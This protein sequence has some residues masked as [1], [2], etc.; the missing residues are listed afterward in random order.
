[1]QKYK[2]PLLRGYDYNTTTQFMNKRQ[3]NDIS[4]GYTLC[5]KITGSYAFKMTDLHGELNI[6]PASH[7]KSYKMIVSSNEVVIRLGRQSDHFY[8]IGNIDT[9]T[10]IT[11]LSSN[12]QHN[13]IDDDNYSINESI[14]YSKIA[15]ENGLHLDHYVK[16]NQ[17]CLIESNDYLSFT[18]KHNDRKNLAVMIN[19][20]ENEH[21]KETYS[22]TCSCHLDYVT[23]EL[24]YNLLENIPYQIVLELTPMMKEMMIK[25][26]SPNF[27]VCDN[28]DSNND[29][30]KYSKRII[31]FTPSQG[32]SDILN[33]IDLVARIKVENDENLVNNPPQLPHFYILDKILDLRLVR[34]CKC[35]DDICK[36]P[37]Q[38]EDT[39]QNNLRYSLFYDTLPVSIIKYN[40][41]FRRF[42]LEPIT[43]KI[44]YILSF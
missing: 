38:K 28:N 39:M 35:S 26:K 44:Y 17:L 41:K 40:K 24:Y 19:H 14:P 11:I 20:E 22:I 27:V 23:V 4:N 12:H 18:F 43:S 3:N 10:S 13:N 36:C 42:T 16:D 9:F 30:M 1:M 21:E 25:S 29:R 37:N 7:K 15:L 6:S 33:L 31:Q 34:E 5:G 8:N 32:I 2:Q